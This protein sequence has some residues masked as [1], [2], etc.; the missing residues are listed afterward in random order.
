MD[1]RGAG[2]GAGVEVDVQ[3]PLQHKAARGS[4]RAALCSGHLALLHWRPG[5]VGRF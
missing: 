5:H 2:D 4:G 3:G 1:F